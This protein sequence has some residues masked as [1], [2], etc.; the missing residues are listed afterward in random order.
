MT[1]DFSPEAENRRIIAM[2][3]A[4]N[5]FGPLEDGYIYYWPSP[6]MGAL[7]S[8]QLRV[9]ADELDRRNAEWDAQ[10]QAD[11][12]VFAKRKPGDG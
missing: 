8:Y 11:L 6:N 5:E 12:T 10:V 9:I 1:H 7:A 2:L 4:R 3:D